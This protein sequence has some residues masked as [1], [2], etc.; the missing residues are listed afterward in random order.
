MTPDNCPGSCEKVTQEIA[1]NLGCVTQDEGK[2]SQLGRGDHIATTDFS[3]KR[4]H[5]GPKGLGLPSLPPDMEEIHKQIMNRILFYSPGGVH[6][7]VSSGLR[8]YLVMVPAKIHHPSKETACVDI[9]GA[10]EDLL[11]T[12]TLQ[13]GVKENILMKKKIKESHFFKCVIFETPPPEGG[14][15]VMTVHMSLVGPST[16]ISKSTNI[17]ASAGGTATF[18]QTDKPLYKAGQTVNFRILTMDRDFL[19]KED[20]DPNK[21]CIGQWFDLKPKQGMIDISYPLDS[22]AQPGAYTIITPHARQDFHVAEF[23]LPTF[24]VVV[25][26]PPV[27]TLLDKMFVMKACGKYTFGKPVQGNITATLCRK[28]ICYY[29]MR[30]RCPKDICTEYKGH[31]NKRGCFEV[32]VST[33]PYNMRSYDYQLNFDAHA[34]LVENGTGVEMNGTASC[35]ISARIATVTFDDTELSDS[36]YKSA[37]RYMSKLILKSPDGSPMKSQ[38]LYMTEKYG[39]TQREHQYETDENGEVHFI[40]NTTSWNGYPVHL[41][42]TYQKQKPERSHGQLN[43]YYVDAFRT[44]NPFTTVLKSYIKLQP[45]HHTLSCGKVH[46]IEFDYIIRSSEVIFEA[47]TIE[48]HYV[49]VA[50]GN[51]M[52]N[53]EMDVEINK[54]SVT[55]GTVMFPLNVTADLAPVCSVFVYAMLSDGK[56][57][58]D[59]EKFQVEKCFN[60]KVTVGLSE[61]KA[62]PGSAV[63]LHINA[64]PG[65][66]CS[67]RAVDEGVMLL[68]PETE[69]SRD[70]VSLAPGHVHHDGISQPSR[71]KRSYNIPNEESHDVF[72]LVK[73]IAIKAIT[74]AQMK[75]P[76]Q[77]RQLPGMAAMNGGFGF[78]LPRPFEFPDVIHVDGFDDDVLYVS[79]SVSE[80][81]NK[82][83][84]M[85]PETWIW[86]LL[87][88]GSSGHI[89]LPVQLPD[90]VTEWKITTY[91]M[92]D[93]G[94]GIANTNSITSF[95]PFFVDVRFPNSVIKGEMFSLSA[96]VFNYMSSPMMVKLNTKESPDLQMDDCPECNMPRCLLPQQTVVF[97]WDAKAL[98]LGNYLSNYKIENNKGMDYGDPTLHMFLCVCYLVIFSQGSAEIQFSVEAIDTKELCDGQQPIVPYSG[99]SDSVMKTVLV[100]AEGIPMTL[101][102]NSILC[103]GGTLSSD[104]ISV[105]LP[106]DAVPGSAVAILSVVGDIMGPAL[107]GIE[108]LLELPSG[109]GEQIMCRF[110]P[111][112][113]L[114]DYMES[115]NLLTEEVKKKGIGYILHGF[116]RELKYRREDGSF[117]TFGERDG[118]GNTWLSAFVM[119]GFHASSRY[120]HVDK[121]Y[122]RDTAAWLKEN[123]EPSGSFKNRGKLF[124]SS[125]KGGANDEMSLNAY[126][127]IALL[128]TK[129]EDEMV[130]QSLKYLRDNVDKVDSDYTKSMLT[131]TFTLSKDYKLRDSL[132]RELHEKAIK[133]GGQTHWPANPSKPTKDHLWSQPNSDEVEMA[134]YILLAHLSSD[135][136]TKEDITEASCIAKWIANQQN[137]HG[138]FANTQDTVIA[139]QALALFCKKTYSK[140]GGLEILFSSGG[141]KMEHGFHVEE[142]TRLLVQKKRLEKLPGEYK[143]QVKGEGCVFLK[144]ALT[145]NVYPKKVSSFFQIQMNMTVA[146]STDKSKCTLHYTISVR[147][148]GERNKT[149]MVLVEIELPSGFKENSESLEKLK[150]NALVKRT[151]T[152]GRKI[153]LYIQEL[154]KNKKETF[155]L[156]AERQFVVKDLKSCSITAYDYYMTGEQSHMTYNVPQL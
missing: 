102:H 83:R 122:I 77:C 88:V 144:V 104:T 114:L 27:V 107:Q 133:E 52:A 20:I 7:L 54:D 86:D 97:T 30:N 131:Y 74:N 62:S 142:K 94:L 98:R 87:Q 96:T 84:T 18:I 4:E 55:M 136:L 134:S 50:K 95:Q 17:L 1:L 82:I 128:E 34:T 112:I 71:K 151:E 5:I 91:C 58:A 124:K 32:D 141:K 154:S 149:N 125:I 40:L 42:A 3:I 73:D 13:Y 120:I 61:K 79:L 105:E 24:E 106:P 43:P 126:T 123:Q 14:E 145:Y 110:V 19:A 56:M 101:S 39:S 113:Y 29:W 41:T 35:S 75:K 81:T 12:V 117:S 2:E 48:L 100:K 66:L 31:T 23:V 22:E 70:E 80:L 6:N 60:N 15:E 67:V 37:L 146:D 129:L 127:A 99:S 21:N 121:K 36:Y 76:S 25:H 85:F 78:E 140:Q 150:E 143:V 155:A 69:I 137:P 51:I 109:C 38:T 108:N 53:G 153:I 47:E 156:S 116:Q 44:L 130:E 57:A 26:L 49:V 92:G 103:G 118:S 10:R 119:K 68:R 59:T 148:T 45:V 115:V 64:D 139:F 9:H 46:E 16:Q 11:C 111:N 147:Y 89:A 8:S 65:S 90:T 138:G 28:A 33:E 93:R 135:N 132:L 63:T 152:P 72:K